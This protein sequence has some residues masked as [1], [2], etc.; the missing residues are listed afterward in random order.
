VQERSLGNAFDDDGVKRH[1]NSAA[2]HY[3]CAVPPFL[4]SNF[5]FEQSFYP[6]SMGAPPM[7]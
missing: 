4:I 7:G 5:S 1:Q 3:F 2:L 6:Q